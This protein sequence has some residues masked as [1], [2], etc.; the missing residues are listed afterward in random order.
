MA[1]GR[2][3]IAKF[4][5]PVRISIDFI[6]FLISTSSKAVATSNL[7]TASSIIFISSTDNPTTFLRVLAKDRAELSDSA[8]AF[9]EVAPNLIIAPVA[10]APAIITPSF[11]KPAPKAE[12]VLLPSA[13]IS[14]SFFLTS[15]ISALSLS[16]SSSCAILLPS[17]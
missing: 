3:F 13:V 8:K 14:P 15:P 10:K 9:R 6:A 12:V 2:D 11:L 5:S 17:P 16:Q 4:I 1:T 7:L